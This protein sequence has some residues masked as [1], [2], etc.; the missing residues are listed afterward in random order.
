MILHNSATTIP[1]THR[2][3]LSSIF[4][5]VI[6]IHNI[7]HAEITLITS[8]NEILFISSNP[9]LT[10]NLINASLWQDDHI[11]SPNN[12]Y[13]SFYDWRELYSEKHK[14]RL[15]KLKELDYG[16]KYGFHL[17]RKIDSCLLIYSFATKTDSAS[18]KSYYLSN[19]NDI[20]RIGDFLYRK[21]RG[22]LQ[23]YCPDFSLPRINKFIPFSPGS[24]EDVGIEMVASHLKLVTE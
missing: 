2:R 15:I 3:E 17:I 8:L 5:D 9:S 19:A 4:S 18:H 22:V 1:Y 23:K 14:F 16:F 13:K 12:Y 21:G 24:L 7:D 10:S 20:L 6:S 11:Y